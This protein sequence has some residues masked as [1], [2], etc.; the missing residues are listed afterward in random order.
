MKSNHYECLIIGG[1]PAALQ[2]GLF[3]GR[4]SVNSLMIGIPEKSDLAYGRVIGNYFGC[5]NEAPGLTL[6][7]NGVSQI[8][9]YGVEILK[10]EV[11]SVE[12]MENK[13]QFKVLTETNKEFLADNIIIATG[14][15]YIKA[16]LEGEN[17][18]LGKGVHTC[19]ACDGIFYKNKKVAVIG[20]GSHA[21]Q[22]AL[23]LSAYTDKIAIFTQG[24]I[25]N[26]AKEL[27]VLAK[28]KG[29]E[30]KNEIV[31]AVQGEKFVKKIIL[32]S[33]QEELMDGIFIA[34]GAASSITFA[35]KLGLEQKDGFITASREAET[36]IEGVWAAGGATGGNAQIAKSVG[37]GCN[38]AIGVIKKVKGLN[39]YIDQT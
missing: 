35:Y 37:E 10:E 4:A 6:L 38:A 3:L 11:V 14:Q 9:K 18:F 5:G 2:A 12:K 27:E 16:G 8:K 24:E 1:G 30:I 13:S 36:N 28:N 22:E 17:E 25:P 31:K 33:G 20:A 23:E 26:W 19:V 39:Q 15:A 34:L 32:D 29:I 21:L 7:K